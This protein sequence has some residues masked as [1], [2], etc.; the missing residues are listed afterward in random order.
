MIAPSSETSSSSVSA[1]RQPPPSTAAVQALDARLDQALTTRTASATGALQEQRRMLDE[2]RD[3]LEETRRR[4][5]AATATSRAETLRGSG[6]SVPTPQDALTRDFRFAS[7]VDILAHTLNSIAERTMSLSSA[8][9]SLRASSPLPSRSLD[10]DPFTSARSLRPVSSTSLPTPRSPPT[11]PPQTSLHPDS[12]L[13]EDPAH[14]DE[15]RA[16]VRQL[17]LM[18][19]RVS[20][21]IA[22]HREQVGTSPADLPP[23]PASS[24][25]HRAS[26]SSH[27]PTMRE[28]L[29]VILPS[30]L[31][32]R[33][34]PPD[35]TPNLDGLLLPQSTVL[36]TSAT[37][38]APVLSTSPQPMSSPSSPP[39]P[40]GSRAD[41]DGPEG[42]GEAY[43]GERAQLLRIAQ[44]QSD[45][46]AR[47]AQLRTLRQRSRDLAGSVGDRRRRSDVEAGRSPTYSR[48]D[49]VHGTDLDG[50][51]DDDGEPP[52]DRLAG[53]DIPVRTAPRPP[54]LNHAIAQ[55]RSEVHGRS[56]QAHRAGTTSPSASSG[57]GPAVDAIRR[58]QEY[59]IWRQCGR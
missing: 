14:T 10:T 18:S 40:G 36:G 38:Q 47:A 58:K 24:P 17:V 28:Q 16:I 1:N 20:A 35:T 3:R 6:T 27:G 33:P 7:R 45:I 31:H 30:Y 50:D 21:V 49:V 56:A 54:W 46:A 13:E 59:E 5:A 23:P 34:L 43:P 25:P 2:V 53:F 11:A 52:R 22:Q 44:L 48:G 41:S 32:E 19:R 39:L 9:E 37:G 4:I 55:R 51:K 8:I 15:V 12:P 26:S 29:P 57:I 42:P